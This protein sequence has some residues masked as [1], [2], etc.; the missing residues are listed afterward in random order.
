MPDSNFDYTEITATLRHFYDHQAE[1]REGRKAPAW[2]IADRAE[3]LVL[4]Q[5]EGAQ[6]LLEIGAG[7]GWC[8]KFFQD[9]GFSVTCTD[10]SP[11]NVRFCQAK[12]LVAYERDFLNLGFPDASFDAVFALNCLLHVPHDNL[13]LVLQ[14]IRA[15]LKPNGLFYMGLYGGMSFAGMLPDD[16]SKFK[17]FFCFHPDDEIQRIVSQ[18][19]DVVRF[20]RLDLE[21]ETTMS[22]QSLIL[23]RPS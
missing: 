10:L 22:F 20:K 14:A 13:P 16:H 17:R 2:K 21:S 15:V 12:G 18:H 6:T 5:Q 9:Q 4:L 19:F 8:G 11:E 1:E 7:T 3:F 23:R